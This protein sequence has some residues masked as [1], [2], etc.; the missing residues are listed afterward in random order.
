V[1]LEIFYVLILLISNII[2]II[3]IASYKFNKLHCKNLI[4]YDGKSIEIG[5]GIGKSIFFLDE[6]KTHLKIE[7]KKLENTCKVAKALDTWLHNLCDIY[8]GLNKDSQEFLGFQRKREKVNDLLLSFNLALASSDKDPSVSIK[9]IDEV[10]KKIQEFLEGV[11]PPISPNYP[12]SQ[13]EKFLKL[14][15]VG[16]CVLFLL[17]ASLIMVNSIISDTINEDDVKKIS[18]KFVNKINT[19]HYAQKFI[20]SDD[21]MKQSLDEKLTKDYTKRVSLD[22]IEEQNRISM[23]R[24]I[25]VTDKDI[26]YA[27]IVSPNCFMYIVVRES[28]N[29]LTRVD[30]NDR[31]W[32]TEYADQNKRQYTEYLSPLYISDADKIPVITIVQDITNESDDQMGLLGIALDSREIGL[33]LL[34]SLDKN[35]I[36]LIITDHNNNVAIASF[37]D[38][39]GNFQNIAEDGHCAMKVK[40]NQ[41]NIDCENP[42]NNKI[43]N[44]SEIKDQ[45]LSAMKGILGQNYSIYD[46][47]VYVFS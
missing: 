17:G 26:P 32:C 21:I 45:K 11:D 40:P 44:Y 41:I 3:I 42:E 30:Y 34:K 13:K 4:K 39:N 22:A 28:P 1:N 31:D 25:V 6:I 15:F 5:L 35:S 47:T 29:D 12:S 2:A 43:R 18:E 10:R 23:L 7:P 37:K 16:T 24:T 33:D 9:E 20:V 8:A 46:W 38:Q 14:F 36:G 27:W 19:I